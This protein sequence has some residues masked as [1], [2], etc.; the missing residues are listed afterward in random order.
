MCLTVCLASPG[1]KF[2]LL[3]SNCFLNF[4]SVSPPSVP[5][6]LQGVPGR[7][8]QGWAPQ[9][10]VTQLG[11]FLSVSICKK[12]VVL[13]G[14]FSHHNCWLGRGP[15]MEPMME[16]ASR[17]LPQKTQLIPSA[18]LRKQRFIDT[19]PHGNLSG[20]GHQDSPERGFS[21]LC[22]CG[23]LPVDSL[24]P[25]LEEAIG[26]ASGPGWHFSALP[27][28]LPHPNSL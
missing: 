3:Y 14:C 7:A 16:K 21:T 15:R 4:L 20:Y 28:T 26:G 19:A 12:L 23:P 25:G 6:S 10:P 11:L 18:R 17:A 1:L 24:K 2:C 22:T 13:H 9:D 5:P 27:R 8:R